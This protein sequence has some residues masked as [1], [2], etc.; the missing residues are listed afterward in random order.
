M[1][2]DVY[3]RQV[4]CKEGDK[5]FAGSIIKSGVVTV[6]ALKVGDDTV[7]SRIINMVENVAS[8]KAPIQHYADQFSNYLVPLNFLAAIAVYRCV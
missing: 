4:V 3:K 5:I 6:R 7:V 1:G 2:E 8:Q